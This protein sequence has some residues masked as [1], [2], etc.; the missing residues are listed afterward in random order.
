M[1]AQVIHLPEQWEDQ[2]VYVVSKP[3]ESFDANVSLTRYHSPGPLLIEH[4]VMA[5]PI[6]ESL[7][8]LLVVS[9]GF[10]TQ[11]A[12][13]FYERN[14]RFVDAYAGHLLQQVQR[15]VIV[16]GRP[17]I[18]TYTNLAACFEA[19]RGGFERVFQSLTGGA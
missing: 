16:Q 14:Y 18:V 1:D 12:V 10:Q 9:Q 8:A 11:G 3:S 7:Q 19:D 5:M 4:M 6:C 13:R 2:S 17:F 15:F